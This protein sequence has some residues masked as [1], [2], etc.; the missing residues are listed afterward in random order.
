MDVFTES[1]SSI[2]Q[3]LEKLE[4]ESPKYNQSLATLQQEYIDLWRT[5][6]NSLIV[7]EQ[8]YATQVGFFKSIPNFSLKIIQNMIEMSIESYLQ[9]NKFTLDLT[10]TAKQAFIIFNQNTKMFFSLNKEIMM[11][12][13][14]R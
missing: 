12:L 11:C 2:D 4:K 14:P 10:D 7:L 13:M 5:M 1:K 6:A 8:E 3:V 9:Q